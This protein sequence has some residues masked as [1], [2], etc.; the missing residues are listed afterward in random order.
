MQL[1]LVWQPWDTGGSA[2]MLERALPTRVCC[3]CQVPQGELQEQQ[4]RGVVAQQV[5]L[6][7]DLLPGLQQQQVLAGIL[8]VCAPQGARGVSH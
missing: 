6:Q 4:V 5:V 3:T 8:H 1:R 7:P 2:P